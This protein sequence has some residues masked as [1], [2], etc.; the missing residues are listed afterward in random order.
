MDL[1]EHDLEEITVVVS[2]F[3]RQSTML[4]HSTA[5]YHRVPQE[6][7]SWRHDVVFHL[8]TLAMVKYDSGLYLWP[9]AG[10]RIQFASR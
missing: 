10:R 4:S 8:H 2:S 3:E 7:H 5:L 6:T 9:V 1:Q